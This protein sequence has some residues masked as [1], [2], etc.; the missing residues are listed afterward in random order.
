MTDALPSGFDG[1]EDL[2]DFMTEPSPALCADLAS[3]DG[4]IMVI[5]VGGKM[6]PTLARLAKRAAPG[7]RVIGVARFSEPGLRERL[8]KFGVETLAGDLLNADFVAKLPRVRNVVFMA[9]RK[10][11]SSGAEHLTWAMN[12]LVPAMVAEACRDAR[13]VVFSTGCVYPFVPVFGG[14]ATESTP[15]NPPSG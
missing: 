9:G 15:P 11:G 6:G 1:V 2:E 5:G 14:G 8:E 10:F 12:A 3:V 7:K 4:D 13:I